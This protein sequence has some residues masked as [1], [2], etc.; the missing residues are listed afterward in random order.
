MGK[1]WLGA[2]VDWIRHAMR[3][4]RSPWQMSEEHREATR[5]AQEQQDRVE[6]LARQKLLE[7]R[8]EAIRRDRRA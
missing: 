8:V 4:I 3:L 6:R 7:L 5:R 1:R 2:C